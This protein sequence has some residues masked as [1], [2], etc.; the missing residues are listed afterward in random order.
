MARRFLDRQARLEQDRRE[1]LR[2]RGEELL[3]LVCCDWIVCL[4]EI[5]DP[6]MFLRGNG[7]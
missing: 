3:R 1:R 7:R 2:F 6:G 4:G 5:F